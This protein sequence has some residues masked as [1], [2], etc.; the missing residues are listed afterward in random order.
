[1]ESISI[2]YDTAKDI[3]N[4]GKMAKESNPNANIIISEIPV[5]NDFFNQ[6]RIEVNNLMEKSMPESIIYVKHDNIK[7]EMLV[8]KKHISERYIHNLVRNM[9]NKLREILKIK[10]MTN[11]N[12]N[13]NGLQKEGKNMNFNMM[14]MQKK[15]SSLV[16]YLTN[17]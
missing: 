5:R 15:I 14:N 16:D 8:D 4:V 6:N 11:I 13:N 9:K 1:M 2:L 3:I 10:G 17:F 7:K 12:Y